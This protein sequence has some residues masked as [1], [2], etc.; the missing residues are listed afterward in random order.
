MDSDTLNAHLE[1]SWDVAAAEYR[2]AHPGGRQMSADVFRQLIAV[3]DYLEK[4]EHKD[5][6]QRTTAERA[7]HIY[8]SIKCISDWMG[9]WADEEELAYEARI[10]ADDPYWGG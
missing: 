6:E 1:A 3:I 4:D 9:C 8:H 7:D 5:F 10:R 2:R